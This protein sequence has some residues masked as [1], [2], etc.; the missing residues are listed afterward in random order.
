MLI[1]QANIWLNIIAL[2]WIFMSF[3]EDQDPSYML[4][5]RTM[6]DVTVT[7]PCNKI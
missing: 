1:D 3:W 4:Y 2:D 5:Y 6:F 7:V